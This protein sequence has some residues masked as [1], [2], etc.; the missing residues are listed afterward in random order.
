MTILISILKILGMTMLQNASFTMVSRARNSKNVKYNIIASV[1]SNGMWILVAKAAI[2]SDKWYVSIAY[3][4]GATIGSA[5][6][7]WVSI[8][9]LENKEFMQKINNF[10][11]RFSFKKKKVV[12]FG[13]YR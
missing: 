8:K 2:L 10:W 11:K 6:M 1:V 4:A 3:V 9:Y 12:R 13:F 7:Q 5:L